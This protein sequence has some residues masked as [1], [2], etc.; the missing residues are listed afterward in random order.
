[1]KKIPFHLFLQ[2]AFLGT[3]V[4]VAHAG[5]VI[6][7][8][9]TDAM[10][11]S[12]MINPGEY[13]TNVTL[14]VGEIYNG[15]VGNIVEPF[16]LPYLAPG[17]TVTGATISFY[18]AS[19]NAP[20]TPNVQLYGLTRVSATSSSPLTSDWY[21]GTNDTANTLLTFNLCHTVNAGRFDP[22]LFRGQSHQL[23]PAA[24]RQCGLF[25]V[26]TQ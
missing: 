19:I 20:V 21:V 4:S 6:E 22:H 23:Y 14:G 10:I 5:A 15:D 24:V 25:R 2:I 1:M 7:G 12:S 18:L 26:G 3:L 13:D 16:N 11:T 8:E 17:Q 9:T